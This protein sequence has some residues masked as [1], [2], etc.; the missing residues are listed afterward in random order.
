MSLG[1][2]ETSCLVDQDLDDE[3]PPNEHYEYLGPD[4]RAA[5]HALEASKHPAPW[6]PEQKFFLKAAALAEETSSVWGCTVRGGAGR[7]VNS[8]AARST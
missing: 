1:V 8:M 3:L 6:L 2:R 5:L 7:G 4:Y